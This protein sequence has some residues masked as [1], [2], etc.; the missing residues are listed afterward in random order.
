M[1]NIQSKIIGKALYLELRNGNYTNQIILMPEGTSAEGKYV[2]TTTYRRRISE[3][4]P[5]KTWR[6]M[7]SLFRSERTIDGTLVPLG[8]EH[9]L[10]TVTDRLGYTKGLFDQLVSGGYSIYKQP[11]TVEVT[12]EDLVDVYNAKTPYKVIARITRSRRAL[13]FGEDLFVK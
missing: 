8:R 3:S 13:G 10:A 4:T 6:V 5:R 11:I 12:P 9:A 1:E 7:S 2:P